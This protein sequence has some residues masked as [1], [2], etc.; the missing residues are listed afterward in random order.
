MFSMKKNQTLTQKFQKGTLR[1]RTHTLYQLKKTA[2]VAS[3]GSLSLSKEDGYCA[4]GDG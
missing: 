4:G 1:P 2:A 3:A